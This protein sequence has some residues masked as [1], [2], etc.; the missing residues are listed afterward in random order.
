MPMSDAAPER[1]AVVADLLTRYPGCGVGVLDASWTLSDAQQVLA[2]AGL[3][4]DQDQV[5]RAGALAEFVTTPD[6]WLVSDAA[7]DASRTGVATRTVRL[8][9][10]KTADLHLVEV[11]GIEMKTVVVLVPEVGNVIATRPPPTAVPASPR[12]GELRCDAFGVVTSASRSALALLQREDDPI[13]GLPAITLMHPDDQEAGI[14]NWSAAKEQRGVPL[15]ARMRLV[16]KDGSCLWVELTMTNEIDPAGEGDVRIEV[17][18]I[19]VEVG[20]TEALT[21]ERELIGLLT[22][23]LP[24]G[25]SKFDPAG[26]IEYANERLTQL[27]SP[28]DPQE[29]FA[30]AARGELDDV[31]LAAAFDALLHHGTAGLVVVDH[32][33]T[34][35]TLVH[36]EWTFRPVSDIRGT[37]TGGVV[38]VADVT[39]AFQLRAALEYRAT[40]DALT[41]CLNRAGT[42]AALEHELQST[43][44]SEGVGL[45]FLDLDRFKLVND[46]EGHAIGDAVLEVVAH[47]LRGALQERDVVGRLGGDEFVVISP[48]LPSAEATVAFADEIAQQLQGPATFGS[49]TVPIFASIG[50]AWTSA[51]TASELLS[52]ADTAMYA[53]KKAKATVPVLSPV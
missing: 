17:Y 20:V 16:R 38:C 15:R 28:R 29:V 23:T 6:A 34:D 37:V 25:V 51:S 19:S 9:D 12:G 11:G 26:R 14:V 7:M 5:L 10:G 13:D 22:E 27:L 2:G 21:A 8:R 1:L 18:D 45:L 41:G 24:V 31:D 44:P 39:E 49:V 3:S 30:A 52:A 40:T 4:I 50:V 33:R 35:G 43:G 47:R 32:R 53:A 48:G 42:I 36:L 46:T